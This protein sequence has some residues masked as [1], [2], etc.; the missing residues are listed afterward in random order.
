MKNISDIRDIYL[1]KIMELNSSK[2]S[3]RTSKIFQDSTD[4]KRESSK[5]RVEVSVTNNGIKEYVSF[6]D[7]ESKNDSLKDSLP[8]KSFSNNIVDFEIFND[9]N[10]EKHRS[11]SVYNNNDDNISNDNESSFEDCNEHVKDEEEL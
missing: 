5:T 11:Q 1:N 3:T 6:Y 4:Q 2:N 9:P 7:A 10:N 8:K